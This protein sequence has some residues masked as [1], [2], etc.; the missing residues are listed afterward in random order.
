MS[1]KTELIRQALGAAESS[2]KLARQLL[3]EIEKGG[4]RNEQVTKELPGI[5][6]LFDG[7]SMVTAEGKKYSVPE[8]YASKSMLVVGDT[9]KMVEEGGTKRFKQIE[10]V[11][12]YKTNGV[13][14][15]KDG[16]WKVVTPEGSYRV[17]PVSVEHFGAKAGDEVLLQLPANNLNAAF[18]VIEKM[19][20][21]GESVESEKKQIEDVVVPEVKTGGEEKT[22]PKAVAPVK[23]E[24]KD[25]KKEKPS[26]EKVEDSTP[27]KETK[28]EVP[29]AAAKKTE[30]VKA[31]E[32]IVVEE[33]KV[34][35]KTEEKKSETPAQ[36]K[37]ETQKTEDSED[38]DE[39]R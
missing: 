12:R 26:K 2:I 7:E 33:Q 15:K 25:S 3:S 8:N 21:K 22:P 30:E 31:P 36:V 4:N 11:K 10:H 16:K 35:E 17:L 13:L 14:A 39:L 37:P 20:K 1:N 38:E 28:E 29:A 6:G 5:S 18:G 32:P 34:P 24:E 19:M 27:V 9:L 23:T